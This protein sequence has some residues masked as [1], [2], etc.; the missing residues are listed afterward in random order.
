MNNILLNYRTSQIKLL[1][2]TTHQDMI[3]LIDCWSVHISK[4]FRAW[5]KNNHPRIHL[6][7][8]LANCTSI[9]QPTDVI[10]QRPFKHVFRMKFNKFI[11]DVISNQIDKAEDLKIDL[12]MSTLRPKICG[13]FFTAWHNLT[14]RRE[15]V[16]KCLMST[17]YI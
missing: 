12:K 8:K 3:W 6:L 9:F 7:F 17:T 13:W 14:T 2:Q 10:L 16:K 11:M 4:E 15:M 1:G 5:M